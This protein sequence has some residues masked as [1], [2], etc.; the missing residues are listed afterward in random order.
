MIL[1]IVLS[2]LQLKSKVFWYW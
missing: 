1:D 2:G